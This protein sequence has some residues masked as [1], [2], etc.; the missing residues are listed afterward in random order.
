MTQSSSLISSTEKGLFIDN[1]KLSWHTQVTLISQTIGFGDLTPSSLGTFLFPNFIH[2]INSYWSPTMCRIPCWP[3]R[4]NSELKEAR[5]VSSRSVHSSCGEQVCRWDLGRLR[6]LFWNSPFQSFCDAPP[7]YLVYTSYGFFLSALVLVFVSGDVFLFLFSCWIP[8]K[9]KLI[10][11]FSG[12]E[13]TW[14]QS[15]WIIQSKFQLT[16]C[17][18]DPHR[19]IPDSDVRQSVHLLGTSIFQA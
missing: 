9:K 12:F 19:Q 16:F 1:L 4:C 6:V 5:L 3:H 14:C 15:L 17:L 18:W 13:S 8:W 7:F 11:L 2:F 10:G